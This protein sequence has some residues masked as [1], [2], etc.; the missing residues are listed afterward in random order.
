MSAR[1]TDASA[2]GRLVSAEYVVEDGMRVGVV[3]E[4]EDDVLFLAARAEDD[5]VEVT[6][7]APA[8]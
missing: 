1:L 5:Q 2:C 4:F 7:S 3:V 8:G 6:A